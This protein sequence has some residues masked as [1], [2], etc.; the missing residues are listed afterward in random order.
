MGRICVNQR[1]I[2]NVNDEKIRIIL[3]IVLILL[4]TISAHT[5]TFSASYLITSHANEI[6]IRVHT[7]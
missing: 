2:R 5:I 7:H 3:N 1:I 6:A 4:L